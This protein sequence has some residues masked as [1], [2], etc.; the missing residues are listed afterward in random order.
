MGKNPQYN[1]SI[2]SNTSGSIWILLTRHI[3]E[4]EDFKANK[5]YITLLAYE[6]KKKIYVPSKP[7]SKIF[8]NVLNFL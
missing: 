2:S 6:G 3:T 8:R 5:E 7:L 1:L 4:L